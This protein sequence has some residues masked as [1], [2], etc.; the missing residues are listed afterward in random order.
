[1]RGE[2]LG[3]AQFG[4]VLGLAQFG[5]RD[6]KGA[7]G[8]LLLVA[9]FGLHLQAGRRLAAHRRPCRHEAQPARLRA[10]SLA[11]ADWAIPGAAWLPCSADHKDP[12]GRRPGQAAGRRASEAVYGPQADVTFHPVRVT[13]ARVCG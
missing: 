2:V 13:T 1:L 8:C 7:V 4:E 12:P 5:D 10:G 11:A 9:L 6:G 3:L